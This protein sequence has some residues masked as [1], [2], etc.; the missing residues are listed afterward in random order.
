MMR[1]SRGFDP[2]ALLLAL[3]ASLVLAHAA[4]S[5]TDA[6]QAGTANATA[7]DRE[8]LT[9]LLT[10]LDEAFEQH[11]ADRFFAQ[12]DGLHLPVLERQRERLTPFFSSKW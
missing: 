2:R 12:F 11:S 1:R 8:E 4:R 5:Q 7:P 3:G 6:S 10:A 9:T